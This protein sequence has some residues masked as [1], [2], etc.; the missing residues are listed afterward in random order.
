[1]KKLF[2]PESIVATEFSQHIFTWYARIDVSVSLMARKCS[3]LEADSYASFQKQ[4]DEK[5]VQNPEDFGL[6]MLA[7]NA[8]NRCL[9]ADMATLFNGFVEG[10]I[11]GEEFDERNEELF[12]RSDRI[13]ESLALLKDPKY[14]IASVNQS[15]QVA[16][17]ATA[18]YQVT[19]LYGEPRWDLNAAQLSHMGTRIM[20]LFQT[21]LL[22]GNIDYRQLQSL[23]CDVCRL[24]D[25]MKNA[26]NMPK[27]SIVASHAPLGIAVLFIE[28]TDACIDWMTQR[29]ALVELEG[30][31]ASQPPLPSKT[32]T[33]QTIK[34][35]ICI[36]PSSAIALPTFGTGPLSR[37]GGFPLTRAHRCYTMS[38]TGSRSAPCSGTPYAKTSATCAPSS[39]AS[40]SVMVTILAVVGRWG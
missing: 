4:I 39:T 25:A 12:K 36:R 17:D 9:A 8:K 16:Q 6:Q 35:D 1:M 26:P 10:N 34:P 38:P 28:P 23:S 20:H 18:S 21:R 3:L 14:V 19:Q 22:R 40:V 7:W 2:T 31:V 11:S 13:I 33:N 27:G 32:L 15:L 37:A 24:F 30:F 29:L 5:A